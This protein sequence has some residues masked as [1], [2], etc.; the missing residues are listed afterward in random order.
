MRGEEQVEKARLFPL[1]VRIFSMLEMMKPQDTMDLKHLGHHSAG[2]DVITNSQVDQ[3]QVHEGVEPGGKGNGC[4]NEFPVRGAAQSIREP[5][6]DSQISL[7][8]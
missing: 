4:H 2:T 3:E 8:E 6:W 5:V 1:A 7:E